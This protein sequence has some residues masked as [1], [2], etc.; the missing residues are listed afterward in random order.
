MFTD[1]RKNDAV[2]I[3]SKGSQKSKNS[4]PF[5]IDMLKRGDFDAVR[6]FLQGMERITDDTIQICKTFREHMSSILLKNVKSL[7]PFLREF[8]EIDSSLTLDPD[9]VALMTRFYQKFSNA[10]MQIKKLFDHIKK[11][12]ANLVLESKTSLEE[13]KPNTIPLSS[14][15]EKLETKITRYSLT[16]SSTLRSFLLPRYC[17]G[18]P[19]GTSAI[20]EPTE[21]TET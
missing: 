9:T 4:Q 17:G 18:M 12:T 16:Q 3:M 21:T 6:L 13:S 20:T 8:R 7:A 15:G 5:T 2:P 1:L 14:S 11:E 19:T 10:H